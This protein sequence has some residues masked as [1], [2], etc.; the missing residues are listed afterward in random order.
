MENVNKEVLDNGLTIL[1]EHM[2]HVRSISMGVWLK[3]GSRSETRELNGVAHFVE[4]LL[5]KGTD[6]RTAEEI[7]R[8]VDTIGGHLDAF[9]G[10]ETVCYSAKVLDD[11][12]PVA[13]DI[14]SD[15]VLNP[16]FDP[17]EMERER[18][19]VLEE[20]KMEEDTP[21]DLI[22]EIFTQNFWRNQPLGR[23][24]L[25]TRRTVSRLDRD[26]VVGFF[27]EFY[28]PDQLVIA[29]AGN[30]DH[31]H[32]LDLVAKKFGHLENRSNGHDLAPAKTYGSI[33]M[34]T[35]KELEQVHICLGVPACSLTHADRFTFYI[36]STI[37]GAGMSSRLFQNIREKQGLAYAIY[38]G[39]SSF[40]DTGCLSV[41][42]GTSLENAGKVV[43]SIMQEFRDLKK[44]RVEAEE[45]RRAKDHLKGSLLLSLESSSSRM[46][47]LARQELYF[48]DYTPPQETILN[49]EQVSADEV[50]ALA[51]SVFDTRQVAL[52]VLG[53]LDGMTF[54]R[55]DL[56]C[57]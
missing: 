17:D 41:S 37:L 4:H 8:E 3:T 15:L 38:S 43:S 12:L 36:L 21:D 52:T 49:V 44:R 54:S 46:S 7:A 27:R 11:H 5:F 35:K 29:A 26:T 2:P 57:G 45:L 1:T 18:R 48:G 51:H 6:R 33:S 14:L 23:P 32:I 47:N 13:F 19:V 22:C 24:I 34:R 39:L 50:Q 53:N 56:D 40:Q 9:T 30:V 28:A 55:A 25:G 20:I 10:K 31:P 16:K 42:A